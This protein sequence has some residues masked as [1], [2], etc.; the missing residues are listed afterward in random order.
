MPE[1]RTHELL[2]QVV[3]LLGEIKDR[4]PERPKIEPAGH[5]V[6]VREPIKRESGQPLVRGSARARSTK[7]GEQ[8]K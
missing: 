4:L 2:G 8:D 3:G 6:E 1:S 5:D 7:Q